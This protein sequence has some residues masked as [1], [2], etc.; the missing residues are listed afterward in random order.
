M[1]CS[2]RP[3]SQNSSRF[4]Q[5]DQAFSRRDMK[6]PQRDHGRI[7]KRCA[8]TVHS[9]RIACARV[10]GRA[11]VIKVG[12]REWEQ[13]ESRLGV[14]TCACVWRGSGWRRWGH[15]GGGGTVGARTLV[16]CCASSSSS[17]WLYRISALYNAAVSWRLDLTEQL[18]KQNNHEP[19]AP[20]R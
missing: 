20:R 10:G 8:E 11:H 1:Q 19:K 5:T 16:V 4:C 18:C 2:P 13:V 12:D 6:A 3:P 15:G 17:V 7:F 9:L 14:C